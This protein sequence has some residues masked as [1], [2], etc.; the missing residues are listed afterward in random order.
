M[1]QHLGMPC[2]GGQASEQQR[3]RRRLHATQA[4]VPGLAVD[5]FLND[6]LPLPQARSLLPGILHCWFG[7][8]FQDAGAASAARI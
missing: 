1:P 5:V 3:Q 2:A 4:N 8:C 6:A 7:G